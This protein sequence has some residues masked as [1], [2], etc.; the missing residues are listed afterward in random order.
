MDIGLQGIYLDNKAY[1]R[2]N[3]RICTVLTFNPLAAPSA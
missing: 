2:E 3:K 1:V